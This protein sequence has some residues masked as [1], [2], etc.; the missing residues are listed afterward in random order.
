[1]A[2]ATIQ[3]R[4]L[5]SLNN[6]SKLTTD[7]N[8]K[9]HPRTG[10]AMRKATIVDIRSTDLAYDPY[11][12]EHLIPENA[13]SW[14]N[15]VRERNIKIQEIKWLILYVRPS[16]VMDFYITAMNTAVT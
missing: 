4:V 16:R 7:P 13:N 15:T 14:I 12:E 1:M 11:G 10:K 8:M 6:G 9:T 5:N 2:K 3:E